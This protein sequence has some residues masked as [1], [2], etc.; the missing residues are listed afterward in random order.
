MSINQLAVPPPAYAG[1]ESPFAHRHGHNVDN[2]NDVELPP[3]SEDSSTLYP[4]LQANDS[5]QPPIDRN[6]DNDA[7]VNTDL[8]RNAEV[9]VEAAPAAA[10]Q[11]AQGNRSA[12]RRRRKRCT[13]VTVFIVR[14]LMGRTFPLS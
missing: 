3:Y 7:A 4:L 11:V 6:N 9:H 14:I 10:V 8:E 1:G 13:L 2:S 12:L 5:K